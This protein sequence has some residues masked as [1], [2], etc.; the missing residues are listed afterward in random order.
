MLFFEPNIFTSAREKKQA[1]FLTCWLY[2][3]ISRINGYLQQ[4]LP[5]FCILFSLDKERQIPSNRYLFT[6][7]SIV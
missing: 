7:L 5:V 2:A 1:L 3:I 4:R 6:P